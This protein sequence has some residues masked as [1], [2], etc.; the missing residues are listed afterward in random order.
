MPLEVSSEIFIWLQ[1]HGL[2]GYLC[3][4]NAPRHPEAQEIAPQL[5]L[6]T[7]T[8]NLIRSALGLHRGGDHDVEIPPQTILKDYF[9]LYSVSGK[10]YRTYRG[11][12][13]FFGKIARVQM[14]YAFADT[15]PTSVP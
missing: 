6:D 12:N 10:E 5:Y 3:V 7:V 9:G 8:N 14:E 1:R 2:G 11:P 13:R 4:I 15:N